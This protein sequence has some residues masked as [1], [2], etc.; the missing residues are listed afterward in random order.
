M[1]LTFKKQ[2]PLYARSL[3][4]NL[5]SNIFLKSLGLVKIF[6]MHVGFVEIKLG[7]SW[8]EE[9]LMLEDALCLCPKGSTTALNNKPKSKSVGTLAV[10]K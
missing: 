7:N 10:L 3:C 9:I 2:R 5:G 6:D 4:Y 1:S 8:P